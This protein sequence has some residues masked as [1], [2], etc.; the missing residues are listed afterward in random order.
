MHNEKKKNLK[1]LSNSF[2][3]KG[4]WTLF[5]FLFLVLV[6]VFLAAIVGNSYLLPGF[7]KTLKEAVLL[8]G[9]ISFWLAFVSTLFRAVVAFLISFVLGAG[10]GI[11]AY[12]F[13]KFGRFAFPVLS[14]FRSL[15]TM[16]ILL[17]I[18][19]W[20]NA[21]VAPIL[22]ACIVLFPMSFSIVYSSLV[23][24]DKDLLEMSRV[25][26]VSRKKIIKQLFIP[27]VLPSV[28][29]EIS[30][31][32]S[33]SLKLIVS[34]EIMSNTFQSIGGQMQAAA[35]YDKTPLLFA[36]TLLVFLTG[37]ALECLGVWASQKIEREEVK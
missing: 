11:L 17:M 29:V 14:F 33:F 34:A 4:I 35:L 13:P 27:F 22:V 26:Q 25:Y 18:L 8:L 7:F 10:I 31:T 28:G 16:A 6:W 1:T 15:P 32:L 24:V 21:N 20:T 9:Q 2:L 3:E 23:S 30:T 36:L 12:C 5:S 19:L 37:Y